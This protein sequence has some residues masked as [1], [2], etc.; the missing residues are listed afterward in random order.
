MKNSNSI[1]KLPVNLEHNAKLVNY[2]P[3]AKNGEAHKLIRKRHAL[4]IT[5]NSELALIN[6]E[7]C[8]KNRLEKL[9]ES[10]I[11]TDIFRELLEPSFHEFLA[12]LINIDSSLLKSSDSISQ[13][14]DE[15]LP[16]KMRL[17]LNKIIGELVNSLPD[18]L[19]EDEKYFRVSVIALGSDSLIGTMTQSL[20]YLFKI[21][22]GKALSEINWSDE[23]PVTGVPVIER[24][25]S[26]Y[27]K[28]N[29]IILQTNQ[30]IR[31]YLDAAGYIHDE[32]PSYSQLYF[33]SGNHLCPGMSVG[34]EIWKI[35]KKIFQEYD[36]KILIQEVSRRNFDNVFNIYDFIKVKISDR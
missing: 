23:P 16:L 11:S 4:Q 17:R 6:F 32:R 7:K 8:L 9:L 24:V 30:R 21:N 33:G 13:I 12:S 34:R 3:I 25:I 29:N 26:E 22:S 27:F 35:I 31:L 10:D 18:D 15:T 19:S 5:K 1:S 2:F 14:L 20:V 36:K 28:F